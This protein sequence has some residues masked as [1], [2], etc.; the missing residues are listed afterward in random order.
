MSKSVEAKMKDAIGYH[1]TSTGD[2]EFRV[3]CGTWNVNAQEP[4]DRFNG[5][6]LEDQF[7]K[8]NNQFTSFVVH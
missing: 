6:L 8:V 7:D 3:L 1:S 5:W 4:Q 2:K